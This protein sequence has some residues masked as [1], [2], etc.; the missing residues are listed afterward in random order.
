MENY[1]KL[2]KDILDNGSDRADRTGVGSRFISGATLKFDLADGFPM[3]TSRKVSFRIA[4]EETMMF[5]RGQT[6]TTVLEGKNINIWTGNTTREFLDKV[7]LTN[8]P[9]GSLGTGYSHAWRNFGGTVDGNDGID[10]VKGLLDGIEKDPNG[11]RHIITAW[12]PTQLSGT[13]LPP[14]HLMQMYTVDTEH[15]RLNSCCVLRSW[16][17]IYGGPYNIMSYAFLNIIFA[18]L[19][20]Y[21]PGEL[22]M[23]GWDAHIYMNQLDIAKEQVSRTVFDLPKLTIKKDIKT[24]DDILSLEYSDIDFGDTYVCHPD[25]KNKPGMAI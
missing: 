16:D 22:T 5:L 12:N 1:I 10:Q 7:G 9:V 13:P 25:F 18:K 2:I 15:N 6:D 21:D 4:F 24:L 23:F 17:V 11:R 20:G 19:L 14:C 3:I 8:L